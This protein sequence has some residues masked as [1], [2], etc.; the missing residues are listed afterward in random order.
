MSDTLFSST[1]FFSKYQLQ[2]FLLPSPKEPSSAM[3]H[4]FIFFF[5]HLIGGYFQSREGRDCWIW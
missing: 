5:L 1:K 2:D 4:L 3:V